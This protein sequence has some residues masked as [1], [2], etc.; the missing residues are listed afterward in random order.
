GSVTHA[1]LCYARRALLRTQ[2]SVTPAGLCYAQCNSILVLVVALVIR[3][4]QT[5]EMLKPSTP[6]PSH[7]SSGSSGGDEGIE[8][9]PHIV[10]LQNKAKREDF[11]PRTLKQ[12]NLV[13]DK[14]ML[15]S[16]L[17]YKGT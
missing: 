10:F 6:S 12:M 11:C 5:A 17:R 4:L 1:G 8:Y 9:Y 13:I 16:R 14:L 7:E 15:H 2:G 3:F